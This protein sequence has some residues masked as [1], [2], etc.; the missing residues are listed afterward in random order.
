P[1]S[2][3]GYNYREA[4]C[5]APQEVAFVIANAI[6]CSE[7]MIRRGHAVDSFAPRL[8]FFLS[9][10][11]DFFEE[12][13]KYRAARRIWYRVMKDQFGAQNP[14]SMTFRFHVQTAGVALTAQQP[15]NNISRAAYHGL[16]AVLGGAQ[17]VHIDAYDEALCTP[18]ELSALTALRT[19]QILQLETR[20]THTVDPLGGSYFVES[21]TNQM[22]TKIVS[23]LEK[24]DQMGGLVKAAETGWI[25]REIADSAYTYQKAVEKG[26]LPIVGVNCFR[27]ENE[28]LPMTLFEVP[29]T[30]E[31]QKKKLERIKKE[32]RASRVQDALD[33]IRRCCDENGN[34]MEVMVESVEA[35]VTEGEISNVLKESY[36]TWNP[37]LF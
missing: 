18:T 10:Y 6:A 29:E 2:F 34:I 4:G 16:S 31:I 20:V 3:T 25:H 22:E 15:L 26:E 19:S 13:A 28:E 30:L 7:E 12:I 5:D 11:S 1:I 14:R 33:A 37:P 21:L 27:D 8:S 24:I 17:S 32:R 36:G 9:G 35:L 23:L